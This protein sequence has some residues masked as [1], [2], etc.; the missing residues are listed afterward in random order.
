MRTSTDLRKIRLFSLM[1]LLRSDLEIRSIWYSLS[2]TSISFSCDT[3]C[4]SHSLCIPHY[5]SCSGKL[6]GI[7]FVDVVEGYDFPFA[8]LDALLVGQLVPLL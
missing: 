5:H 2:F 4:N 7:E 1:T 3:D 6:D 8:V